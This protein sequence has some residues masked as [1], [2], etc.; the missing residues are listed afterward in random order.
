MRRLAGA[1]VLAVA[2]TLP[3]LAVP[4][5]ATADA[6]LG[7]SVVTTRTVPAG[8][9][10]GAATT[11]GRFLAVTGIGKVTVFDLSQ[12]A[13]LPE[14]C[15]FTP[16]DGGEP[17]SVDIVPNG[18]TALVAVKR[19]PLDG[20]VAAFDVSSCAPLWQAKVGM[21]PDS[22][23]V[24]PNGQQAL[25]AIEAEESP[26]EQPT[27][28]ACPT[29]AG[30]PNARPGRVDLLDLRPGR[31]G[32][33]TVHPIPIDLLGVSGVNCQDDP[34]PEG[35]AVSGDSQ[36][37]YVTLQENNALATIN[38]RTATVASVISMGTTTHL[39]DVVNG[40]GTDV[41]DPFTGRRESD[42]IALSHEAAGCSRPTRATRRGPRVASRC[43][44]VGGRCRC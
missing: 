43:S 14:V 32:E 15:T 40:S 20:V 18:K 26:I 1:L 12:P 29:E 31:G 23:V 9:E 24:A 4:V 3:P 22:I 11:D 17:T 36:L 44:P 8:S 5:P 25:V 13:T 16:R 39:A 41:D 42:G 19:D 34:Q 21:G 33:P 28:T 37:A 27:T 35:L 6:P 30:V 7:F 10:I 2:F 38:L